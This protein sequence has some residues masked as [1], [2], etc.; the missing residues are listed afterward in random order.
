VLP[1]A[2]AVEN[3]TLGG[4]ALPVVGFNAPPTSVPNADVSGPL[5]VNGLVL[6]LA[7]GLLPLNVFTARGW[8]DGGVPI[9]AGILGGAGANRLPDWLAEGLTLDPG[10]GCEER[11][12]LLIPVA[13]ESV[14]PTALA[15]PRL[16]LGRRRLSSAMGLPESVLGNLIDKTLR[17]SLCCGFKNDWRALFCIE[18]GSKLRPPIMILFSC[19]QADPLWFQARN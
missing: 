18:S 12:R 2:G 6:G 7:V 8:A 11:G 15:G 4:G 14:S 13:L 19:V 5:C 1:I 16:K 9:L 3:C 17:A 10:P